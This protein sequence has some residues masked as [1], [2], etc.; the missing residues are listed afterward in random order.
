MRHTTVFK[1]QTTFQTREAYQ[2]V[3]KAT[4]R[5]FFR[6]PVAKC[7]DVTL[8]GFFFSSWILSASEYYRHLLFSSC[9]CRLRPR[10]EFE[11]CLFFSMLKPVNEDCFYQ[12]KKAFHE[13]NVQ[14]IISKFQ[15][16]H[17]NWVGEAIFIFQVVETRLLKIK[18]NSIFER[19]N[20]S[21]KCSLFLQR[22]SKT[23]RTGFGIGWCPDSF[24]L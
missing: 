12:L 20:N 15:Y 22:S 18:C 23:H 24:T 13:S 5:R 14:V 3:N 8:P 17:K 21:W 16:W 9:L 6:A 2:M 4:T 1:T 19:V 7:R 11:R 10:F